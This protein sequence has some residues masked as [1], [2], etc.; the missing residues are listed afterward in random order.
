MPEPP[1]PVRMAPV[2]RLPILPATFGGLETSPK[3]IPAERARPK[4]QVVATIAPAPVIA[5]ACASLSGL[6]SVHCNRCSD[7]P[8]LSGIACRERARLEYCEG[9]QADE[10][11]CPSA[12]PSANLYSPPG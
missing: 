9:V 8:G 1:V 6:E 11:H 2:E 7:K 3:V 12:I 4:Q 5:N 10:T